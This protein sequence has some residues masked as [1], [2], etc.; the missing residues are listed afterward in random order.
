MASRRYKVKKPSQVAD[1]EEVKDFIEKPEVLVEQFSKTE[2][3]FQKH[4][5][6]VLR[7]AGF[8]IIGGWWFPRI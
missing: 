8:D 1:R 6:I 4:K 2:E 7:R 3:F 5:T